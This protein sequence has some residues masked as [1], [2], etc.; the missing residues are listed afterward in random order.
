MLLVLEDEWPEMKNRNVS[1]N[2][3]CLGEILPAGACR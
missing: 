3:F 1:E 2:I